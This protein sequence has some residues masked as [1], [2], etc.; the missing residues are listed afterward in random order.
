MMMPFLFAWIASFIAQGFMLALVSNAL[1][2]VLLVLGIIL[3]TFFFTRKLGGLLL[4]IALC[5]Y[6]IYPMMYILFA[7]QII[8]SPNS[9]WFDKWS[10]LTCK[11]DNVGSASDVFSDTLKMYASTYI[12]TVGAPALYPFTG[13]TDANCPVRFC[14]VDVFSMIFV[15]ITPSMLALS[16][17]DWLFI[18][19]EVIGRAMVSAVF[20]PLLITIITVASI[21]GLSPL[22]GGD[23]EIAGLTHLI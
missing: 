5:I 19:A 12:G 22:L 3:R 15:G 6:T 14:W 21:K 17:L 7:Q 1:F 10:A 23:V 18:V 9:L 11:C 8:I 2:P 20:V 4:A 16:Q 13:W